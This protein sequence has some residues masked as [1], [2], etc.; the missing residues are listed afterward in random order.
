MLDSER[1]PAGPV[2]VADEQYTLIARSNPGGNKQE[3]G[4]YFAF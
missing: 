4:K 2:H 1:A 3:G